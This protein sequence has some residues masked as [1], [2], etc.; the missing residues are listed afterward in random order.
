VRDGL[1]GAR[2]ADN[3]VTRTLIH[4]GLWGRYCGL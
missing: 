2:L 4:E 3:E 1:F